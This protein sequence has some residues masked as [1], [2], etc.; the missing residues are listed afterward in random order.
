MSFGVVMEGMTAIS[1]IVII[2]GGKQK[3]ESG[4]HILA[5]LHV[6]VGV[7]LGAALSIIVSRSVA[8]SYYIY[9]RK[10]VSSGYMI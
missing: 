4:W 1:Y 3:R 8:N 7:L 10:K 9:V 5:G 6:I 2:A